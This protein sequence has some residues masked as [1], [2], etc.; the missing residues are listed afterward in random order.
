MGK[1]LMIHLRNFNCFLRVLHALWKKEK[2][3]EKKKLGEK[4]EF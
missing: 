4:G 2:I 3:G 1:G